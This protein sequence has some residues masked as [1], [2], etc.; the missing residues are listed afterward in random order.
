ML[1]SKV[2]GVFLMKRGKIRS[3]E[4]KNAVTK[5]KVPPELYNKT[6]DDAI[7]GIYSVYGPNLAAF[8]RDVEDPVTHGDCKI[9]LH[10]HLINAP[11]RKRYRVNTPR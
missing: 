10:G 2:N 5:T 11:S 8:F 6:L 4:G 3:R 7:R 1:R 9:E